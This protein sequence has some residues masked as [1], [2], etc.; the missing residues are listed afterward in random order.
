[1]DITSLCILGRSLEE[2]V[3]L[4]TP[5]QLSHLLNRGN[6]PLILFGGSLLRPK[7][8]GRRLGEGRRRKLSSLIPVT[9]NLSALA[10]TL[11]V[12]TAV[13]CSILMSSATPWDTL[14]LVV[15]CLHL[16]QEPL[17]H[18][19]QLCH[20]QSSSVLRICF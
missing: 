1:M 4:S 9:L 10:V 8:G 19:L 12:S 6:K 15:A 16:P 5:D 14:L 2:F 7:D 17:C 20:H 13:S 18:F 11:L 3:L